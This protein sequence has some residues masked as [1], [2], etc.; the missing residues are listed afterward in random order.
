[1]K[2]LSDCPEIVVLL[3]IISFLM[4]SMLLYL[5]QGTKTIFIKFGEKKTFISNL[6]KKENTSVS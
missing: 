3:P 4:M 1:M 2:E 6:N 5:L